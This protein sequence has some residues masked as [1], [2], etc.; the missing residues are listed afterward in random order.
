MVRRLTLFLIIIA[1]ALTPVASRADVTAVADSCFALPDIRVSLLTCGP[2]SDVYELEGHTGLRI[3]T[4]E[5]DVVANWGMFDFNAPN[6]VG[7]FV[8]GQ[9]DY[10]LGII[11]TQLFLDA[12]TMQRR[13]VEEQDLDLS[14]AQASRLLDMVMEKDRKSVV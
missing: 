9:T 8:M 2:G 1:T 14:S 11:P 5:M 3:V 13:Y 6:F 7:R 12:Y 4:P 10:S